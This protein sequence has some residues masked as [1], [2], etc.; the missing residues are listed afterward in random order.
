M[1]AEVGSY[2]CFSVER[3]LPSSKTRCRL[4][5]LFLALPRLGD[6]RDE[7][8]LAPALDNLLR[9]LALFVELPVARWVLVWGI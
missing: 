6:G 5:R 8:G 3:P 9:R 2:C 7:L 4:L 1:T